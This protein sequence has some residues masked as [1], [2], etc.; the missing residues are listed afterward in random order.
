MTMCKLGDSKNPLVFALR[1]AM[2]Q[3]IPGLMPTLLNIGINRTAYQALSRRHGVNMGNRI[4]LNTLSNLFDM[5][6]IDDVDNIDEN[7]L[8]TE[9]QF[10]RIAWMES[11]IIEKEGNDRLLTDSFHQTL[12]LTMYVRDFISPTKILY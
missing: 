9:K 10:E 7:K 11:K 12:R 3:Y 8:S 1:S 5:L 6:S 4:Y 2:P